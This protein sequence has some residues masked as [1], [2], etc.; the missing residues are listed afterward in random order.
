MDHFNRNQ[1]EASRL[2]SVG[3]KRNEAKLDAP[4][5]AAYAATASLILNLDEAIT[6]Q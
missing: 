6:K 2:L 3:E 5:L 1:Q 4:Q